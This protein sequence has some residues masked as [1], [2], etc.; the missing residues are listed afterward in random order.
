MAEE[1]HVPGAGEVPKKW[2]MVVG[3]VGASYVAFRWYRA[4]SASA[5]AAAAGAAPLPVDTS[6]TAAGQGATGF[7]NPDPGAGPSSFNSNALTTNA[8]WSTKVEQDLV[9][10]GYDGQ[11]VAAALGMYLSNQPLTGDQQAIIRVAWAMDGKPPE[12]P[13]LSIIP[14]QSPPTGGG[15]STPPPP[16]PPSGGSSTPPPP[17]PHAGQ[18][19]QPPQ[20]A[21]LV[22]GVSLRQWQIWHPTNNLAVLE[23]LNPTLNANDTTHATMQIRTSNERWV[24]N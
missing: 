16:P 5:A 13:N 17:D 20:V 2:V 24:P 1:V 18:H 10:M 14:V 15:S 4:R 6:N 21:T 3:G 23:S 12:S 22:H 11:T 7:S 8:Q 9:N 19:L